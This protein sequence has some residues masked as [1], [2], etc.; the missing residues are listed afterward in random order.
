MKALAFLATLA[1]C[2]AAAASSGLEYIDPLIGT[3]GKGSQYG[4]MMPCAGVPFGSFSM[5]P[6]T[7]LNR[8]GQLSFNQ[9]DDTLIGFILTRQPSIWM[10]DW[11]EVRIPI[12]PAKIEDAAYTPYLGRVTAGG[13]TFEYTAT[14]HAA[15]LR[16]DLRDV[17]LVDGYCSNRDDENLG[18]PL[19]NF[20]GWRCVKRVRGGMQIGVSLI[21]LE[22]ARANLAKEI[23]GKTFEEVA[24]AVKSEWE[25]Y[26]GRIEIDAPD[27]VKTIFYTGLYHTLMYPR[28]I[29]EYGRYYSAFDDKVHDGTMYSCYSLWDTYRAEHPWLTL[30]APEHVDG[31]MQALLEMYREGGWLPKWP[32]PSYTG[33]MIGAPAEVVLAEAYVKGFKGFDLALAYEAVR[34]NATVPQTGDDE[35]DWRDRGMFGRTPETR[36]GL[37]SYMKRGYVS[38]D[39]TR[40]SVSRTQDF[41]LADRAA[42]ILAEAAGHPDDAAFFRARSS[43]YTNLWEATAS[44]FLPRRADGTF[45]PRAQLKPPYHDYCEQSPETGVWAVPFDTDGLAALMG[46]PGTA[47]RRLD[48]FFDTLFWIPERGN[49]SIHGNEPSH[50]CAYLYNRFGA[51][52]KTQQR[53]REIL[54]RAYSTDRKGFDGNEDCGQMSAWYI[55]SALGFYPLDPASGEYEIGSPLV[56]SARLHIGAPYPPA[57]LEIRV[58]NAAPARWRVKRATLNGRELTGWRVRHADLIKGGLLEFKM[59]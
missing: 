33:I 39:Q 34:K 17:R 38:C 50:H 51:P 25:R 36:G 14:A 46:G 37:A 27:S 21:S 9:A 13:R 8:V 30:V 6:M 32:N 49:K 5:V 47:V 48:E 28:R 20:K 41:G 11:G 45:V 2:S 44:A 54:T 29:D 18:Y 3:E 56:R 7:R 26:F 59:D 40:E 42:A 43:N 15:W 23:G 12:E 55:F 24:S 31:M 57:I 16:G 22:Q 1:C 53:V 58:E 10:G 4:G 35:C 52:E 19:P